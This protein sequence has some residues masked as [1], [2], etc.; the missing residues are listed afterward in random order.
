MWQR[1]LNTAYLRG[2]IACCGAISLK[3]RAEKKSSYEMDNYI[4]DRSTKAFQ[5]ASNSSLPPV[6]AF[7]TLDVSTFLSDLC[8]FALWNT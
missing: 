2:R 8:H 4:K 1:M 7:I 3:T 6:S 5:I